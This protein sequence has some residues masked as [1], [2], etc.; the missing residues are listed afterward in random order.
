MR[1]A[2]LAI[3]MQHFHSGDADCGFGKTFAPR[4]TETVSD[5]YGDGEFQVFFEGTVQL[6]GGAVGIFGKQEGVVAAKN[7]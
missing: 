4:T 3:V 5:D 7:T 1:I 6:R 2:L